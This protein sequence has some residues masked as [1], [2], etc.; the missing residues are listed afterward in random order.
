MTTNTIPQ[1]LQEMHSVLENKMM[2]ILSILETHYKKP[3]VIPKIVFK[4]RMGKTLGLANSLYKTVTLNQDAC[5]EKYWDMM[6]NDTLGHEVCHIIAPIIYNSWQHGYDR[7]AGW[8][9]G[10]A[11]K[12]CM[13]VIGLSPDRCYKDKE[14]A[15]TIAVR[16]VARNFVYE[17]PC[18]TRFEFTT[19]KHNSIQAG[20]SRICRKC[21]G[22]LVYKGY[23]A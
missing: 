12:E 20:R 9:H 4:P 17:C 10:N 6:L 18:A 13:R 2:E 5:V 14:L 11:W 19:R 8:S 21:K 16:T 3:M 22:K 7:K 1:T 15:S 23:K